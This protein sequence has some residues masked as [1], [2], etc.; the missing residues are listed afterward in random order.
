MSLYCTKH[1][2]PHPTLFILQ[3]R[4]FEDWFTSQDICV[5]TQDNIILYVLYF[6]RVNVDHGQT[7]L[8]HVFLVRR[9]N[10]ASSKTRVY[11]KKKQHKNKFVSLKDYFLSDLFKFYC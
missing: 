8:Y 9:K 10:D 3:C 11:V 7:R 4:M 2:L 6:G 1:P 5:D